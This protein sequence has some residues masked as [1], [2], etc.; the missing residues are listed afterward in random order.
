MFTMDAKQQHSNL[1]QIV[2][3]KFKMDMVVATFLWLKDGGFPFQ[4][5]SKTLDP[6]YKIEIVLEVEKTHSSGEFH[7]SW[8]IYIFWV[9][10]DLEKYH[11]VAK[12]L[13]Q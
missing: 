7:I 12:E 8:L 13:V 3:A 10:L 11:L 6:S 9:I 5:R 2:L 1:D 4:N